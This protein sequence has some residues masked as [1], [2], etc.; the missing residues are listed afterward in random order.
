MM[1]YSA[2]GG[3]CR[4]FKLVAC[5][6]AEIDPLDADKPGLALAPRR[7]QD[8]LAIDVSH[9]GLELVAAHLRNFAGLPVCGLLNKPPVGHLGHTGSLAVYRPARSMI[10]RLAVLRPFINVRKN[11]EMQIRILIK[12]LSLAIRIRTKV[13]G[14]ELRIGASALRVLAHQLAT[15]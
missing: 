13:L 1:Q 15:G 4:R 7:V 5:D 9:A 8:A 10:M 6:L 14:D 3:L 2:A 12:D 11:A